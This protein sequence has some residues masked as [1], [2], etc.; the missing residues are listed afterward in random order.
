MAIALQSP[1]LA[2]TTPTVTELRGVWLTNID[3]DVLFSRWNVTRSIRR[4]AAMNFNTLY[5]TVWNWGYTLYPSRVA[6]QVIGRSLDPTPGLQG[7]DMLRE[8][9]DRG[10]QRNMAVIPWFEFGFMAPADSDLAKRHPTWIT[11][12]RDGTQIVMEGTHPRVWLNPFLPDVQQT[13]L[14]FIREIVTNYDIDGIQFDD[15]FG[16][17]AELGYDAYTIG[18][19]RQETGRTAPANFQDAA[20]TRWRADKITQFMSQVFF[21]IKAVKPDCIVSVSPN[22]Q[23]FSYSAYLADWQRWERAGY[24]EEL[25]VQVYRDSLT[26]FA[27]ELDRPEVRAA[28][29]HIP[30]AVGILAGLRNRDVP[31]AQIRSQVQ[32]ARDRRLAGV[33][34]FFYETLGQRDRDFRFMFPTAARRPTLSS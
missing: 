5:P 20:W 33:S 10:H 3:S 18:L 21:A 7:R 11:S 9:V 12:R 23:Q 28:Q 26:N 1:S 32:A 31:I 24:I 8:V 6:Q 15:H 25:I 22:P 14:A 17:P 29:T 4:L 19:Y 30:T 13:M 27:A 2:Q 16:L 34:F